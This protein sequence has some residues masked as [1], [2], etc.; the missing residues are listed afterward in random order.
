MKDLQLNFM[1]SPD[2]EA[3]RLVDYTTLHELV[4]FMRSVD[5]NWPRMLQRVV[6][7]VQTCSLDS[8]CDQVDNFIQKGLTFRRSVVFRSL[9]MV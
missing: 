4:T 5:Y 1:F 3:P 8:M 2:Y 6:A 9:N 7:A